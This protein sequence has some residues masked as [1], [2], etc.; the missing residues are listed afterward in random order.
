MFSMARTLALVLAVG[1]LLACGTAS[2][3]EIV[4]L[5]SGKEIKVLGIGKVS[6]TQDEPALML[7]YQTDLSLD[8]RSALQE[9]VN[10]IWQVFLNDVE[11]ANLTRAIVSANE[12]PKGGII[13]TNRAANFPFRKLA[14]GTWEQ[15][16]GAS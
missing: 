4:R 16:K 12:V 6:F 11:K 13:N 14:D 10:E 7:K 15:V 5:P 3:H 2:Q 9:E 1:G 8:D